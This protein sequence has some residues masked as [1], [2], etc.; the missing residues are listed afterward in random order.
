V[1]NVSRS[2]IRKRK[3][4]E[5]LITESER[6]GTAQKE[7]SLKKCGKSVVVPPRQHTAE[8]SGAHLEGSPG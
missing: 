7:H 5:M 4:E 6:E 1:V 8:A 3:R 2:I